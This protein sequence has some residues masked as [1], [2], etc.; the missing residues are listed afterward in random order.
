MNVHYK[1]TDESGD[2]EYF[3]IDKDRSADRYAVEIAKRKIREKE[4]RERIIFDFEKLVETVLNTTKKLKKKFQ[5]NKKSAEWKAAEE[6]DIWIEDHETD[7]NTD[8]AEYKGLFDE[9]QDLFDEFMTK[10]KNHLQ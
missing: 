4:E 3:L 1:R 5:T 2:S 8:P 9:L 6:L 10:Y 7:R